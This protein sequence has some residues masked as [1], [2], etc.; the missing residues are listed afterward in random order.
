MDGIDILLGWLSQRA[1]NCDF[2]FPRHITMIIGTLCLSVGSVLGILFELGKVNEF[3]YHIWLGVGAFFV[4]LS[5]MR[6]L[7]YNHSFYTLI[8]TLKNAFSE[9]FPFVL[10]CFATNRLKRQCLARSCHSLFPFYRCSLHLDSLVFFCSHN[11]CL[12]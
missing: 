6:Y 4:V 9:V 5:L 2:D 7:E 8:L 3:L 1:T 11:M 10:D 12:K